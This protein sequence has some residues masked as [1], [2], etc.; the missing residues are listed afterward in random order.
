MSPKYTALT[1][2]LPEKTYKEVKAKKGRSVTGYIVEAV[3]EKIQRE[4]EEEIAA[5]FACLA[6]EKIDKE[7]KFWL[8][9]QKRAMKHGD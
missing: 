9:A 5:G 2:R 4:R 8:K 3:E 6:G 1:L 7:T